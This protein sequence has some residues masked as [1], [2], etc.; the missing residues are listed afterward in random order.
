MIN[1]AEQNKWAHKTEIRQVRWHI[2]KAE[3]DLYAFSNAIRFIVFLNTG[4]LIKFYQMY[5]VSSKYDSE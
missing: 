5:F 4:K 2:K 1:Q 3:D